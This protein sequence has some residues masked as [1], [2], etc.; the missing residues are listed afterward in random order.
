MYSSTRVSSRSLSHA[1]SSVRASPC[2]VTTTG[3]R[4]AVGGAMVSV[5]RRKCMLRPVET[6]RM[7]LAAHVRRVYVEGGD[8]WL[9]QEP[10][11]HRAS[12]YQIA[13]DHSA[14]VLYPR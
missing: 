11:L 8:D 3:S 7:H 9:L 1:Y 6:G 5:M 14:T 10:R 12:P 4:G 2:V 13:S